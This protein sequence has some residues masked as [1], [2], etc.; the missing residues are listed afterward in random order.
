MSLSIVLNILFCVELTYLL[1]YSLA[2]GSPSATPS[3][4]SGF[5]TCLRTICPSIEAQNSLTSYFQ[6]IK[7]QS[8]D[9]K[10]VSG[11]ERAVQHSLQKVKAMSSHYSEAAQK[12][13]ISEPSFLN[14]SV[15]VLDNE[16]VSSIPE[17]LDHDQKGFDEKKEKPLVW[18]AFLPPIT[19][20]KGMTL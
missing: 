2:R 6:Y 16:D 12:M 18:N 8:F 19:S 1:G 9:S 20:L 14:S 7:R 4:F 17:S 13:V 3:R 15:R 10:M 11:A 5:R